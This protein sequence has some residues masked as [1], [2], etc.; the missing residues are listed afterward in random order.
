MVR[1]LTLVACLTLL[2]G[3]SLGFLAAEANRAL[4]NDPPQSPALERRVQ[5]YRNAYSL[6]EDKTARVRDALREYDQRLLDLYR[7]L[8]VTH[9]EEFKALSDEANRAIEA[10]IGPREGGKPDGGK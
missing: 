5:D 3:L 1:T 4:P 6:S 9:R 10:V 8:R 2:A 7:K